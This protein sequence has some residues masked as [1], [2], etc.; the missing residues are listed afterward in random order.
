MESP[1]FAI[2]NHQL[3]QG[4]TLIELLVVVLI[5]GVLSAI[6][7][8]SYLNQAA[9][10]R[11]SEARSAIGAINRA[12]Q[13]YYLERGTMAGNSSDLSIKVSPKFYTYQVNLVDQYTAES[14]A[15]IAPA[16]NERDL[17]QYDSAVQ[18][19]PVNDFFGQIICESLFTNQNPG[20]ATAPTVPGSRGN[21]NS[22]SGKILD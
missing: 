3:E 5:I 18:V 8:P 15:R 1:K 12:Q 9:K 6:A 19:N 16:S 22:V 14:T 17:K 11:A 2:Q 21:C 4:F 13:V 20:G 10:A 7:L